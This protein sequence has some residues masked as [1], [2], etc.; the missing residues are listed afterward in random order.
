M[1]QKNSIIPLDIFISYAHDDKTLCDELKK[2]LKPLQREGLSAAWHDGQIFPGS[3]WSREITQH[4]ITASLILLLISPDFLDSDYC[5]IVEMEQ[6][7]KRHDE[8]S[9]VV[10]PILL[11]HV[12][13]TKTPIGTLQALPTP[14]LPITKWSDRD[15]AFENVA[16]GIRE[17]INRFTG[18]Q[19]LQHNHQ[20]SQSQPHFL[21]H[22]QGNVANALLLSNSS[23]ISSLGSIKQIVDRL[24]Q[25]DVKEIDQIR[26][27]LS[28]KTI[29]LHFTCSDEQQ[30]Q[31]RVRLER[32]ARESGWQ[33]NVEQASEEQELLLVAKGLFPSDTELR[34]RSFQAKQWTLHITYFRSSELGETTLN[35]IRRSFRGKT[36]EKFSR[37]YSLGIDFGHPQYGGMAPRKKL[38]EDQAIQIAENQ[39]SSLPGFMRVSSEQKSLTLQVR[40][41]FPAL[42]RK[43]YA[44]VLDNIARLTGW[45]IDL[46][47]AADETA[48]LEEAIHCLPAST[49]KYKHS[50]S[51]KIQRL[52]YVY[53]GSLTKEQIAESTEAFL[54]ATGWEL[55]LIP[56]SMYVH[57]ARRPDGARS[58]QR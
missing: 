46:Y 54:S 10:I 11:R 30:E 58:R 26:C 55:E 45:T 8:G 7:L 40:F 47:S 51:Q 44:D 17:V 43:K 13:W 18:Q 32:A 20:P 23:T 19:R 1:Q 14:A 50:F 28:A 36:K 29:W 25:A 21:Q 37:S 48:L 41:R 6:A 56:K 27:N 38:S 24:V 9:A 42:I 3:E 33:I 16:K 53:E 57:P 35:S 15:E 39:L 4:L 49:I 5:Y 22:N 52:G 34:I 31:Y 12:D 2:H